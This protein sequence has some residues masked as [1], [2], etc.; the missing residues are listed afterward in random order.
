MVSNNG[1]SDT[2]VIDAGLSRPDKG[3]FCFCPCS[4]DPDSLDFEVTTGLN[5]LAPI[6]PKGKIVAVVHEDGQEAVE[7]WVREFEIELGEL[8]R[9]TERDI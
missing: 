4:G 3:Y 8:S 6:P 1:I 2:W 5:L 9:I 7:R